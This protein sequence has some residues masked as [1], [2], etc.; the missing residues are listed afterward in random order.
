MKDVG[1]GY[2]KVGGK[3]YFHGEA[4][5]GGLD[6]NSTGA[7]ENLGGGYASANVG[8]LHG[9]Q[10]FYMG[11]HIESNVGGKFDHIND[12]WARF[13][14]P[15]GNGC[16]AT[17]FVYRGQQMTALDAYKAGCPGVGRRGNLDRP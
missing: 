1:E 10:L 13:R 17:K 3:I 9:R 16:I 4:V 6:Y 7:V 12:D 15:S 14:G 5:G 2:A 8:G 11:K